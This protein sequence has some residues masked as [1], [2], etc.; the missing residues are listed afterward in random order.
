MQRSHDITLAEL[1]S[2]HSPPGNVHRYPEKEEGI[3]LPAGYSYISQVNPGSSIYLN[4]SASRSIDYV[5]Y[6]IGLSPAMWR[7]D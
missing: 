4:C 7:A 6:G 2:P 5:P 3:A 1:S